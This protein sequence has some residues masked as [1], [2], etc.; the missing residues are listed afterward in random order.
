ML[1]NFPFNALPIIYFPTA[2]NEIRLISCTVR[3]L[4]FCKASKSRPQ[5]ATTITR[6]NKSSIFPRS[7]ENYVNLESEKDSS[8]ADCFVVI[9]AMSFFL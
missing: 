9:T 3:L 4:R 6:F 2:E 1:S 8:K 5:S 7:S